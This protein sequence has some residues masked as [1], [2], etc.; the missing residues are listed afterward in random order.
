VWPFNR[1]KTMVR[2]L[3]V[4]DYAEH[5][6]TLVYTLNLY[7]CEARGCETAKEAWEI[8][9]AWSP[10]LIIVDGLLY[11]ERAWSFFHHVLGNDGDGVG[12]CDKRPYL[13]ALTG[14]ASTIQQRLCQECGADEYVTKP[15]ELSTLLGWVQKARS[16]D[17]VAGES[18][19]D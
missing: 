7:G 9:A 15:I 1:R 4:D 16:R 3:V 19:G 18:S 17:Y 8:C 13:V 14:F 6:E 12:L 2:A 11:R 10:H 5:V